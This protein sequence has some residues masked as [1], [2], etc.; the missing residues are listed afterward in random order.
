MSV[1]LMP[2]DTLLL[3]TDGV[4]EA[5]NPALDLLGMDRLVTLIQ[6]HLGRSA[7]EIQGAILQEVQRFMGSAP[8]FD[9]IAVG[10]VVR[11]GSSDVV[12]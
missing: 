11:D 2:G 6:N 8:Q 1:R 10:V 5:Q 7:G 12:A 4:T 3:Y 9:D